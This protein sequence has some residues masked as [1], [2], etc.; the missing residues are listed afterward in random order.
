VR[1][2]NFSLIFFKIFH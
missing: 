2:I 1:G